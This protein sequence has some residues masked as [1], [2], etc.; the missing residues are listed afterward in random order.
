MLTSLASF[1]IFALPGSVFFMIRAMLAMGKN[2]SCS[3]AAP[4]LL[5]SLS[6]IVPTR[7][8]RRAE[9]EM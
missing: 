8:Q 5:S 4:W 1:A 6:L 7:V 9:T 3:R 2:R